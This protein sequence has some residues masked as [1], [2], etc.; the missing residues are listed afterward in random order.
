MAAAKIDNLTVH[1]TEPTSQ[2]RAKVVNKLGIRCLHSVGAFC[3]DVD[4]YLLV[5]RSPTSVL[6]IRIYD[7]PDIILDILDLSLLVVY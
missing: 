2:V 3:E 5:L 6:R 7:G 1:P 4:D